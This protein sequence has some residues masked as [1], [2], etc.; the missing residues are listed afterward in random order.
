MYICIYIYRSSIRLAK[1]QVH[2]CG[3]I[4]VYVYKN[5]FIYTYIYWFAHIDVCM[6]TH[7]LMYIHIKI[8]RSTREVA[9]KFLQK[10]ALQSFYIANSV[11]SWFLRICRLGTR[12]ASGW[13]MSGWRWIR[14]CV[15]Y[16][17]L[18]EDF[19]FHVC[20]AHDYH[21]HHVTRLNESC[22]T[23]ELIIS[24]IWMSFVTHMQPA[25]KWYCVRWGSVL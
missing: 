5:T 12:H 13:W 24:Q 18:E 20:G 16:V 21:C 17:C 11:A 7:V 19:F 1:F 15:L 2:I 8:E 3:S 6:Y 25:Y 4:H 23:H 22:H 14:T 10:S 9:G